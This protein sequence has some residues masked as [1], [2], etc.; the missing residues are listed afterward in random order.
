VD[1]GAS[2]VTGAEPFEP[3]QP[4]KRAFYEPPD[5]ADAGAVGGVLP[6]DTRHD[7][8]ASQGFPVVVVV[9]TAVTV[10][11]AL[12]LPWSAAFAP[13]RGQGL[14]KRDQLGAVVAVAAGDRHRQWDTASFGDHMVFRA[15]ASPIDGRGARRRPFNARTCEPSTTTVSRSS[16]SSARSWSRSSSCTAAKTPAS[17]QSRNLRQHVTPETPA[18]SRGSSR[19]VIP[20]LSTNTIPAG[21][22][23]SSAGNRPGYRLRRG[24]RTGSNGSTAAT[25]RRAPTPRSRRTPCRSRSITTIRHADHSETSCKN[26]LAC[27][28]A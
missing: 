10:E 15:G 5:R 18:T 17:V 13:D 25:A 7:S 27:E 14:D 19:Q 20:V 16:R 21:A 9:V 6:S 4:G 11:P 24:G 22:A 12:P 26:H 28:R 3:V 2:F 23:R 1:V 8:L